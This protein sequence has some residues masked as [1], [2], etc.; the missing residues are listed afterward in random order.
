MADILFKCPE[1]GKHLAI[2]ES[3]EAIPIKCPDCSKFVTVPPSI[4][5][6]SCPSCK[7]V[8]KVSSSAAGERFYCPR[9]SIEIQ[10]PEKRKVSIRVVRSSRA[11]QVDNS[12][13]RPST[14]FLSSPG[15]S[16]P[17]TETQR[18]SLLS[19]VASKFGEKSWCLIDVLTGE[20]WCIDKFPFEIGS[21]DAVDLKM[22]GLLDHHCALVESKDRGVCLVQKTPDA[23]LLLSGE[24]TA[25]MTPLSPNKDYTLKVGRH[26]LAMRGDK[27]IDEWKNKVDINQ[28]FLSDPQLGKS[29]GPM[30]LSQF[31]AFLSKQQRDHRKTA[32]FPKGLSAGFYLW[33]LTDVLLSF[34]KKKASET[35]ALQNKEM[36]DW[37]APEANVETGEHT[38]A[39]CWLRFDKGDVMHIAM[40]DDLRGD[41]VLGEDALLRFHATRFNN[42]GHAL[43]A[44][45][46]PCPDIACP[47]CRRKLPTGFLDVPYHI[48]SIVGAPSSGKSY[49]LSVLAKVLP[50]ELYKHFNL[51]FKDA[52]PSGNAAL[53][54]MKIRLFS[55]A[56]PDQ[57]RLDKTRLEGTMYE[58]FARGGRIV[59]L[60]KP[61][62]F[63]VVPLKDASRKCS[64]V[65]YD[66]AGEH[67]E[68]G[69]DEVISPGTQHVASATAILFLFDPTV[70]LDFRKRLTEHPDP[71][72]KLSQFV[73]RQ[74]TILSEMDVRVKRLLRMKSNSTL[75]TPLAM[76][77]GKCDVWLH[78]TGRDS[79]PSPIR[80][81]AFDL[82]VAIQNSQIV[83]QLLKEICPSMIGIAE[84]ISTEVMYF[85]VSSFGHSPVLFK[86]ETGES[87]IA[88]DPQKLK[89]ILVEVPVVWALS[90]IMPGLVPVAEEVASN[91]VGSEKLR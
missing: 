88:P 58:R 28:W 17:P 53:N 49:Y 47:H 91:S 45:N 22:S 65:F 84:S 14:P 12:A 9:C 61:F 37:A 21:G 62:I 51:V 73:D 55:G 79:L 5:E 80:D 56:T 74:E 40:H 41:P 19:R 27:N 43:D 60:P 72:L 59:A 54:D 42:Q 82:Q 25:P 69:I 78:L 38:C 32:V 57:V 8:L 46:Q 52:D 30:L 44:K 87:L 31:P 10:L 81:G 67:F 26:F 66:N 4:M 13:T 11:P 29:D 23:D 50:N 7:Q 85:P 71:Q 70:S 48:F 1:C 33:Q 20:S 89:P 68:P 15:Q 64:L 63:S 6:V 34:T 75:N 18:S 2:D 24:K 35:D 86:R 83:R 36:V 77:I 76:L 16:A 3:G 90:K 39:V